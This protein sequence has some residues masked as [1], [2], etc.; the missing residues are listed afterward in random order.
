MLHGV[1]GLGSSCYR[2]GSCSKGFPKPS[3]RQTTMNDDS[4]PLYRRRSPQDGGQNYSKYVRGQQ[5]TYD[6]RCVVPYNAYLLLWYNA[7]MLSTA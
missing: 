6:N 3:R 4:Y 2:N 1:C 5:T 7:Q